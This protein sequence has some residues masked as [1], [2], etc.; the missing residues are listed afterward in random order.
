M[1]DYRTYTGLK[2]WLLES[3]NKTL[4]APGPRK[5]KQWPHKRLSQTC[6]WVSGSL[7]QRCGSTVACHR[8]RGTEYMSSGLSPLAGGPHYC[9]CYHCLASGQNTGREH[10]PAHQ[11][12]IGLNIYWVWPCPLEQDPDS[13]TTSPSHQEASTSLLS[14]SIRGQTD[15]KSQSQKTNQ[16]NHMDHSL[17]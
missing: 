16:S 7:Q 17:V 4:C 6:Q 3:T 5:K 15:W 9:H 13:P 12:K 11:Q 2:N 14:F 1:I 8:V 10:S